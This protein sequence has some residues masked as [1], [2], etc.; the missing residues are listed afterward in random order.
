MLML[1]GL[2]LSRRALLGV[3]LAFSVGAASLLGERSYSSAEIYRMDMPAVAHVF[4][5]ERGSS[6]VLYSGTGFFVHSSGVLVTAAHVVSDDNGHVYK[7]IFVKASN[8]RY[9]TAEVVR[10]DLAHD[11]AVL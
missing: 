6:T 3:L 2:R 7:F 1:R 10:M 5:L 8:G 4:A 9:Y 11:V